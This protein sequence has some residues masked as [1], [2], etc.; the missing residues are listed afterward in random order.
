MKICVNEILKQGL[1]VEKDLD[2]GAMGLETPQIGYPS[3]IKVSA[4]LEKEK[5]TVYARVHITATEMMT[6]SRC[7]EQFNNTLE[8]DADFIYQ[9]NGE[10]I[11][12]LSDNIKDTI[13]LEYPIQQLC[14]AD[15]K[16]L[17]QKCGAN[18]NN[19]L[20]GCEK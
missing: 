16:G 18:L 8:K 15:C 14:K 1:D 17:C 10:H 5:D 20:C 7:L 12:D 19:G 11:I 4:H 2:P 9:L 13:I 6:C 3:K